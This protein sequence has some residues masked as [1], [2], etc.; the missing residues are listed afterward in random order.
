MPI[1]SF[2]VKYVELNDGSKTQTI[3][4]PRKPWEIK[5]GDKLYI[6][7]KLRTPIREK[8]GEGICTKSIFKIAG[9]LNN[10]DAIKDGF[11][12]IEGLRWTLGELHPNITENT[13][14]HIITWDWTYKEKDSKRR[15]TKNE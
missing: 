13:L 11:L 14:V 12:D 5:V 7:W 8:L 9:E 2:S 3:R 10:D 4:L 1:L 6:W 15:R